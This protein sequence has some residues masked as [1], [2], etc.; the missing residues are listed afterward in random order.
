MAEEREIVDGVY[1]PNLEVKSKSVENPI[2]FHFRFATGWAIFTANASTCSF[3]IQSDWGDYSHRWPAGGSGKTPFLEWLARSCKSSP[4]YIAEKFSYDS[5]RLKDQHDEDATQT[6]IFAELL[7][8]RKEHDLTRDEAAERWEDVKSGRWSLGSPD[9]IFA[10][11]PD[12][13]WEM[14]E[15]SPPMETRTPGEMVILVKSLI[16]FF[17][18]V[19]TEHLAEKKTPPPKPEFPPVRKIT[20]GR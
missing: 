20:E 8:A 17:G 12:W 6:A 19:L 14:F 9:I 4:D 5:P 2:C 18:E 7:T 10:T 3:S 15:T 11:M 16:P 1:L 13:A